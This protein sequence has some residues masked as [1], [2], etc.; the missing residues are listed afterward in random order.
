MRWV[1][2]IGQWV[3]SLIEAVGATTQMVVDATVWLFRRP[4]RWRVFLQAMEFVGAGSLAIVVLTGAFTGM[5]MAVQSAYAFKM[6]HAEAL[7]GTTVALALTRELSPVLTGLMVTGRVGSSIATE[8]GTMNV[9]EQVDALRTMAVN[10]IQY[11]VT[12]RMV[13]CVI[14]VPI[15][16]Q[17]CTLVGI[18]G[19]WLVAVKGLGLDEGV[20]FDRIVTVVKPWDVWSGVI[21]AAFFGLIIGVVS[22]F[23]GLHAEGGARGVGVATTRAVV[24]SSV[25]ILITDYFLTV[26]MF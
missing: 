20:F 25:S 7:V 2:S 12:P 1:E 9:T 18:A 6:F 23:K 17:L 13:A 26:M 16:C 15:L 4:F 21:K 19:A 14:M 3:L 22:C 24:V 10:P 8:I 11:L 5:V